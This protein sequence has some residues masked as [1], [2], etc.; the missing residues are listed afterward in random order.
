MSTDGRPDK[1]SDYYTDE[2]PVK[3]TQPGFEHRWICLGC[4]EERHKQ[5]DASKVLDCKMV[6]VTRDITTGKMVTHGQCCCYS[7]EHGTRS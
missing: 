2:E 5:G 6:F 1:Y 7:A 4:V 3:C